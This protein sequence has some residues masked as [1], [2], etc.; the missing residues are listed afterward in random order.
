MISEFMREIFSAN[1]TFTGL[2]MF[3]A[4]LVIF[5]G[6]VW[7]LLGT[8]VGRRLGFLITGAGVSG[9]IVINSILFILYA[10]RGPRQE[11][12]EGLNAFEIRLI[13][14]TWLAISGILFF[15]FMASL[16]RYEAEQNKQM[17]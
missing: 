4:S 7:L 14:I 8:N 10:P 1:I 13:P 11:V 12:I 6:S 16:S 3:A 2:V 15:M 9:W 17:R 5:I